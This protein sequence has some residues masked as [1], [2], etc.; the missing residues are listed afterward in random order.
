[1]TLQLVHEEQEPLRFTAPPEEPR[2]PH[3]TPPANPWANVPVKQLVA[4]FGAIAAVIAARLLL[5]LG[6]IGAFVLTLRVV[7]NPRA[8]GIWAS[9]VYDL[10]VFGP[11]VLLALKKG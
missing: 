11:L 1:M 6:G 5:L 7:D 9:L 10:C 3:T 8:G 2:Q 4:V